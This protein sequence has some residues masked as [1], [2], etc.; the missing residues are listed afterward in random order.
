MLAKA[1]FFFL[2]YYRKLF[3]FWIWNL[4]KSIFKF[5]ISLK[6]F[7]VFQRIFQCKEHL[8]NDFRSTNYI[9]GVSD[10][11]PK[12]LSC[13]SSQG[14]IFPPK[15]ER[16]I[17]L[18]LSPGLNYIFSPL[19]LA[20]SIKGNIFKVSSLRRSVQLW[21][22]VA[23]MFLPIFQA[24]SFVSVAWF[25]GVCICGCMCVYIYISWI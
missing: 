11:S 13:N 22:E 23:W 21:E 18:I 7:K 8:H 15:F 14:L 24:F 3:S 19:P 5:A 2:H 1:G 16:F 25:R 20:V 12:L 6:N 9:K 4:L 10:K 17:G